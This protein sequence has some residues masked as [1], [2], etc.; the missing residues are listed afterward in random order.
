VLVDAAH[1][2]EAGAVFLPQGND[3]HASSWLHGVHQVHASLEERWDHWVHIAIGILAEELGTPLPQH[4]PHAPVVRGDE[5]PHLP[6]ACQW[7]TLAGHVLMHHELIHSHDGGNAFQYPV[8]RLPDCLQDLMDKFGLVIVRQGKLLL[9][10][11]LPGFV[12]TAWD[13]HSNYTPRTQVLAGNFFPTG[14]E[15]LLAELIVMP[16]APPISDGAHRILHGQRQRRHL[17]AQLHPPTVMVARDHELLILVE[18][19]LF[20]RAQPACVDGHRTEA[21]PPVPEGRKV[22]LFGSCSLCGPLFLQPYDWPEQFG[23][24]RPL[25]CPEGHVCQVLLPIH[26]HAACDGKNRMVVSKPPLRGHVPLSPQPMV[27]VALHSRDYSFLGSLGPGAATLTAQVQ[28]AKITTLVRMRVVTLLTDF[29]TQDGYV[30]AMKGVIISMAPQVAVVDIAH[31]I[32]PFAISS[33]AYVLYSCAFFFP[34]GTVHVAVVDPGVGTPRRAIIHCS[35]GHFFVAPDNGVLSLVA[36]DSGPT[37][38]LD[39]PEFWLPKVS[40]TFHGR[41]VFAP[42]AARLA[43]G[44]PAGAMGTPG[45]PPTRSVWLGAQPAEGEQ[46]LAQVLHVDR[47]GNLITGARPEDLP[48]VPVFLAGGREI[49]GLSRTFADVAQ[50][51]LLAYIGSSGLIEI[52][53]REGNAAET[54]GL[55]PGSIVRICGSKGPC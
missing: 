14:R 39:R 24:Q 43:R 13:A 55:G 2:G 36:D 45:A 47:F 38:T 9:P 33:A 48:P 22:E 11:Q 32:A 25:I 1:E 40:S 15:A 34:R 27:L 49:R 50:G 35:R 54:L 30:A 42:V 7:P 46:L 28:R 5:L 52:G 10:Q 29:G 8:S 31:E 12:K 6:R 51:E 18:D 20:L 21:R 41:D 26:L 17:L 53:Q 16:D 44:E 23:E 4:I 19:F 3:I 37:Y